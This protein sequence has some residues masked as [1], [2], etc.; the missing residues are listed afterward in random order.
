MILKS[1]DSFIKHDFP[2]L[3][4]KSCYHDINMTMRQTENED[5]CT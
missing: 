3:E 1:S 4:N 2:D 5:E